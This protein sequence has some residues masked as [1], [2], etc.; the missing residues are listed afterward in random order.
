M[1]GFVDASCFQ[2][3]W[4]F[5][6]LVIAALSAC[7][8][9]PYN[10]VEV[11]DFRLDSPL[12]LHYEDFDESYYRVSEGGLVDVV[13]RKQTRSASDQTQK[14]VQ[15]ILIRSFWKP[16]PG[17]TFAND[18]MLNANLCYVMFKGNSAIS[19]EGGGFFQYAEDAKDNVITGRL[20]GGDL[21]PL[22]KFGSDL[23]IFER[24]RISGRFRAQRD[25]RRATKIINR[26]DHLLGPLPRIE[27]AHRGPDY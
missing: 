26:I 16:F 2:K 24:A 11:A 3:S 12:R 22:R 25:D 23:S 7:H 18:S 9:A 1:I 15:I 10:R 4:L 27:P 5:A 17:R 19:Y 21:Q 20:E 8:S 13:L 14:I 6:P